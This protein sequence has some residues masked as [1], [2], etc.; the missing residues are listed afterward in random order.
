M[1]QTP[2]KQTFRTED[3]TPQYLALVK[4]VLQLIKDKTSGPHE[5]LSVLTCVMVTINHESGKGT[6]LAEFA[7]TQKRNILNTKVI[8]KGTPH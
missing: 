4:E 2:V 1:G 3:I 5:G 7:E 8:E 6:S